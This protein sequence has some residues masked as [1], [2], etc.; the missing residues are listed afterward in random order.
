[1]DLRQRRS[2]KIRELIGEYDDHNNQMLSEIMSLKAKIADVTEENKI[3]MT[4][5]AKT[6]NSLIKMHEKTKEALDEKTCEIA[7][8]K[9][10]LQSVKNTNQELSQEILELK[11]NKNIFANDDSVERNREIKPFSCKYCD[12]S[13]FQVHEVKKHIKIHKFISEVKDEASEKPS[14][15]KEDEKYLKKRMQSFQENEFD[16][17]KN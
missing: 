13:F 10:K 7:N 12:K 17:S 4:L 6:V 8:M 2:I 16:E 9:Q 15:K 11:M 1:M 5:N 3:S 14:S